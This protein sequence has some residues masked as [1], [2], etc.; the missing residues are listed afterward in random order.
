MALWCRHQWKAWSRSVDPKILKRGGCPDSDLDFLGPSGQ[1]GKGVGGARVCA[2]NYCSIAKWSEVAKWVN[3]LLDTSNV[4][5]FI[6]Q[7]TG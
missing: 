4:I 3:I 1:S 7:A 5:M 6:V 2:L